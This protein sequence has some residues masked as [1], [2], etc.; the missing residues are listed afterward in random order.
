MK[1]Y[2]THVIA[3]AFLS[4]FIVGCAHHSD[5]RPSADG[6]HTVSF[7]VERKDEGYRNAYSQA[8]SYCQK[9]SKQTA[10]VV[11]EQSEYVGSV[12]EQNYNTAKT[13]TNIASAV[14]V[15]IPGQV[16][17]QGYRYSMTFRCE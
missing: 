15:E 14:G 2:C 12:G 6:I 17:T 3:I 8:E 4:T 9:R 16:L 13:I 5:V 1:S 10:L 7:M 11:S